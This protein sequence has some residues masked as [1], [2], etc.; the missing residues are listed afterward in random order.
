MILFDSR[1]EAHLLSIELIKN[2]KREICFFGS[3][4]DSVLFS[5][6]EISE[7]LSQFA[8][9]NS[10]TQIRFL[11]HSTQKAISQG[12]AL[13]TLARRLTSSFNIHITAKQHKMLNEQ[14]LL[15]DDMAYLY[16]N[17]ALYYKGQSCSNSPLS[18][19]SY[20]QAFNERW[21]HSQPDI[22]VREMM[23]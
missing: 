12:H 5:G 2:A 19:R 11:T 1:V 6:T 4:I 16:M 17:N 22:N 9:R 7:T 15:V 8:R 18:V 3:D 14:F 10:H 20:K 13:L 23:L 21:E